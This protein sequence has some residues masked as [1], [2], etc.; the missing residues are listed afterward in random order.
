MTWRPWW[1]WLRWQLL[2]WSPRSPLWRWPTWTCSIGTNSHSHSSRSRCSTHIEKEAAVAAVVVVRCVA[3]DVA[4]AGDDLDD[5]MDD[6]DEDGRVVVVAVVGYTSYSVD[7]CWCNGSGTSAAAAAVAVVVAGT[8]D[9]DTVDSCSD[10]A[11]HSRLVAVG[12]AVAAAVVVALTVP[13]ACRPVACR[14]CA[15]ACT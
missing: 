15:T 8:G 12:S 5:C 7:N 4:V 11:V 14:W 10:T 1:K 3:D 13:V 6:V 9:D 2:P